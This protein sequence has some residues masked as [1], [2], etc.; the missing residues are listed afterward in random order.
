MHVV[1]DAEL[2]SA[3]LHEISPY[4]SHTVPPSLDSNELSQKLQNCPTFMSAYHE[5]LR[6]YS[7]SMTIRSVMEESYVRGFRLT[8][9][10]HVMIPYRQVMLDETVYGNE[11]GLYNHKQFLDN[12]AL[13]RSLNYK[14]F[15]GGVTL[16]P[17]RTLAQ[18]EILTFVALAIGKF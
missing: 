17:G 6:I 8:K 7:S 16:C 14:P 11:S 2:N 13:L 9:G 15:G 10:A 12:P 4:I 3:I 1:S 18:K 5:A